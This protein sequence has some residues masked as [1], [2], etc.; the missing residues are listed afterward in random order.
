[1]SFVL[2][3]LGGQHAQRKRSFLSHWPIL[4]RIVCI[5]Y[6]D[7]LSLIVHRYH[8]QILT[9]GSQQVNGVRFKDLRSHLKLI[10]VWFPFFTRPFGKYKFLL[11]LW[12]PSQTIRVIVNAPPVDFEMFTDV[13]TSLDRIC[14]WTLA[15][16]YW[17]W[18]LKAANK[19]GQLLHNRIEPLFTNDFPFTRLLDKV[20]ES[21][22][23]HYILWFYTQ[24]IFSL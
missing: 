6:C 2:W 19:I 10:T 21:K 23:Y 14:A 18:N 20:C 11:Q 5:G 24:P 13:T 12:K 3:R 17:V 1:M 8:Y 22:N 7:D 15:G 9:T 16:P 4:F